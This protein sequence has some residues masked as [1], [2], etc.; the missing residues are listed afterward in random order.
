MSENLRAPKNKPD[1]SGPEGPAIIGDRLRLADPGMALQL[2]DARTSTE[3]P[4]LPIPTHLLGQTFNIGSERG[5]HPRIQPKLTVSQPGDIYEEE[6]DRVAERI[7]GI[8]E[9]S[10]LATKRP[11]ETSRKSMDDGGEVN[12]E[13][14]L[15]PI[16]DPIQ[17][18][19][20]QRSCDGCDDGAPCP[21]CASETEDGQGAVQ[22]KSEEKAAAK[23]SVVSEGLLDGIGSGFTLDPITKN[24]M[25]SRFGRDFSQVRVHADQRA[26][27]SAKAVDALAYTVGRDVVFGAGRYD[28]ASSGG[29]KL[30]A[31]ELAHVVQQGTGIGGAGRPRVIGQPGAPLLH[32][33][34]PDAGPGSQGTRVLATAPTLIQRQGNGGGGVTPGGGGAEPPAQDECGAP[35]SMKKNTKEHFKGGKR[36]EDYYGHPANGQWAHGDTAGPFVTNQYVGSNVQLIGTVRSACDPKKFVITQTVTFAK[37]R[38]NGQKRMEEGTTNPE[39][40]VPFRQEW[41]G[42]PPGLNISSADG[43][44]VDYKTNVASGLELERKF[45]TTISGPSGKESVD[46]STSIVVKDGKITTNKIE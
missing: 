41:V 29:K 7:I 3:R 37:Y 17:G 26:A 14:L 10:S 36:M 31:H 12:G 24:F 13:G 23:R 35:I 20:V 4:F 34:T 19:T 32:R 46:W 27:E 11:H 25:E 42:N 1:S 2:D 44:S 38:V 43:P 40:L 30:L 21:D 45:T 33:A 22:R 8:P 18:E 39:P 16:P 28:V 9:T 5:I 6:A 15:H